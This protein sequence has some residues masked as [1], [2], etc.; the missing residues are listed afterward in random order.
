MGSWTS[1]R[2]AAETSGTICT[3]LAPCFWAYTEGWPIAPSG[4]RRLRVTSEEEV[5]YQLDGD[6]GGVLPVDIETL[7]G[8][9][10]VV[11]PADEG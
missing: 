2:F 10:T 8:R 9:L 5:P 1:A 7:P 3:T 4:A 11:V 6:P